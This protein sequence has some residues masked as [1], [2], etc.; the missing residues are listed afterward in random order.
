MNHAGM[1]AGSLREH[2]EFAFKFLPVPLGV[3]AA[4]LVL[5]GPSVGAESNLAP[6]ASFAVGLAVFTLGAD[7]LMVEEGRD[8]S[9]RRMLAPRIVIMGGLAALLFGSLYPFIRPMALENVLLVCLGMIGS[10]FAHMGIGYACI[11]RDAPHRWR[12]SIVP[13]LG[14]I[15]VVTGLTLGV[16]LA[17]T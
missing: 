16:W 4:L 14:V 9:Q 10:S 8:G 3:L 7:F 12:R 17:Y 6:G 2:T 15:V 1:Q 5:L 13:T 11:Y